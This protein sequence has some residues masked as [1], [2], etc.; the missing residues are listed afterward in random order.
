M[1]LQSLLIFIKMYFS[2]FLLC[3]LGFPY[4]ILR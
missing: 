3:E 4:Y 2:F 1:S